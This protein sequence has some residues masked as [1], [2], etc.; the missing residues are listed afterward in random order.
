MASQ[1]RKLATCND[2]FERVVLAL[3]RINGLRYGDGSERPDRT[4]VGGPSPPRRGRRAV[5]PSASIDHSIASP[6]G[7]RGPARGW[8]RIKREPDPDPCAGACDGRERR[9][10]VWCSDA[11][12]RGHDGIECPGGVSCTRGG[13]ARGPRHS[14]LGA[15]VRPNAGGCHQPTHRR[16]AAEGQGKKYRCAGTHGRAAAYSTAW[17]PRPLL[18]EWKQSV[19]TI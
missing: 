11:D 14:R 5:H 8:R 17:C 2:L 9:R 18:V 12:V 19:F 10:S 1:A 15:R 3:L 13:S 7:A 4:R 16:G 6:V